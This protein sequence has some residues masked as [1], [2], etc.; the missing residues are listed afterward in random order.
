MRGYIIKKRLMSFAF[1]KIPRVSLTCK[2][3]LV[4]YREYKYGL[5]KAKPINRD[6]GSLFFIVFRGSFCGLFKISDERLRRFYRRFLVQK[7]KGC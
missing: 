5:F 6:S 7:R 3:V 2:L 4:Q 1:E